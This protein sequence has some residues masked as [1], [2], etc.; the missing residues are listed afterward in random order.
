MMTSMIRQ[1][2]DNIK[3]AHMLYKFYYRQTN[4]HLKSLQKVCEVFI[5]FIKVYMSQ[6]LLRHMIQSRK[7]EYDI[8]YFYNGSYYKVKVMYSNRINSFVIDRVEN[9]DGFDISSDLF[10]YMGPK[11]NFHNI[12][13]RPIDFN[14]KAIKIYYTDESVDSFEEKDIIIIR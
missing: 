11:Y 10:S 14:Y 2:M 7:N 4:S 3:N 1:M 12:Q 13:Y 9:E 6:L 8:K 5:T